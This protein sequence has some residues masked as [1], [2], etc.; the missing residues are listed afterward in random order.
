[1]ECDF[2]DQGDHELCAFDVSSSSTSNIEPER[3]V[4]PPI[5]D[6]V[7]NE[8]SFMEDDSDDSPGKMTI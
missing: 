1:M 6:F 2:E 5:V 8:D 4:T 3:D 7:Q